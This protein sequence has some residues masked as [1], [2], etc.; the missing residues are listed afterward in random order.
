MK[1]HLIILSLLLSTFLAQSQ[2]SGEK[3]L[4]LSYHLMHPG[5]LS[6]PGDPNAAFYIDG[7]YHLH[8]IL[9]YDW[10]DKKSFSFIHVT[11][12]D[13]LHWEWQPT[14]LQPSF[15]GHGM[16]SGT[17]LITKNGKAA[18]VYHGQASG[19]NQIAIAKDNKLTA[20]EK[21]YAIEVKNADGKDADM[22]H[23][24]PD[25]FIIGDTYYAISGGKNPPLFK[26]HDLKNWLYV[27][28]FLKFETPDVVIGEDISCPNFFPLC[29][30]WMMLCISHPFGCRYYLG[31]WDTKYEQFIP[32]SHGRMNWKRKDQPITTIYYQD[33][34]A[35]ESVLTP[36]G[37]RVMWAWL[38]S[39][40]KS[41]NG[42]SL[43]SLP[44]ELGLHDDG[45]LKISPLKELETLRYDEKKFFNIGIEMEERHNGGFGRK[46]ITDIDGDAIEICATISAKEAKNKRF[47]FFLFANEEHGSGLPI[48]IDP[49]SKSLLVGNAEA[50]FI[51]SDL[52]QNED[53]NIRI[54]I[55]KYLVEV[56]VND[57]QAMVG[58]FK[59]YDKDAGFYVY[60]YGGPTTIREITMWKMQATNQGYY[61]AKENRIWEPKTK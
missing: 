53:V 60:T 58:F 35:P 24:D 6:I 26:S 43:Q 57:R 23:W 39:L 47:G 2:G 28:D 5:E 33:Y 9:R 46:K 34:F 59:D 3:N 14:K 56:F 49:V 21:P 10:K 19:R 54:F 36:D 41:I 40:D 11:S 13:M 38:A 50:P 16:F 29:D 48:V 8:Y 44:R 7:T 42:L 15:T 25:C 18:A 52:H 27:G 17:G 45:T 61:R 55:D 32:T 22:N 4:E 51:V 37:R 1:T 12:K 30:K 31:D 20:W